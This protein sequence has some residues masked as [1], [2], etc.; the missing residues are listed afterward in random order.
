MANPRRPIES[1]RD[2]ENIQNRQDDELPKEAS[3]LDLENDELQDDVPEDDDD[4][5]NF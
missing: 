5:M 3:G 2:I 4:D 1:E